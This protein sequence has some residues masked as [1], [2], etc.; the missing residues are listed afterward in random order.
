[1][2]EARRRRAR[3]RRGGRRPSPSPRRWRPPP[4][5]G[6][7]LRVVVAGAGAAGLAAARQLQ[8]L[9]HS[10]CVIEARE[11]IGGRVHTMSVAGGEVDLGAMVVTGVTG[12][13]VAALCR[14]TRSRMH[15]I[16]VAL[17]PLLS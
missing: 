3:R 8:L 14:Q 16:A 13:P 1:M 17:P 6:G 5:A 10:V 15:A 2:P 12:N 9:G 4:A 11:R 7:S